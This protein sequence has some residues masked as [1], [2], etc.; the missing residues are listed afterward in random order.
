M[1][2]LTKPACTVQMHGV[3]CF[4]LMLAL[5]VA[6]PQPV[7]A[8]PG[9]HY[10]T[11][12]A[13]AAS[14]P[15]STW[16]TGARRLFS[17][18]VRGVKR[19]QARTARLLKK[20]EHGLKRQGR[21]LA[22]SRLGQFAAGLVIDGPRESWRAIEENPKTFGIGLLATGGLAVAGTAAGLP[23]HAILVGASGVAAGVE[24]V[25]I[26]QHEYREAK[27]KRVKARLAG[28]MLWLPV[29]VGLSAWA[30]H[31]ISHHPAP[32]AVG[33]TTSAARLTL[34]NAA[35]SFFGGVVTGGDVPTAAVTAYQE[36][37][38]HQ[39]RTRRPVTTE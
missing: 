18:P 38:D 20:A 17:A 21:R 24:V 23:T 25:Q 37:S 3:A 8:D 35:S 27:S 28:K 11:T 19:L 34:G 12:R 5:A 9:T 36:W 30:G 15:S 32:D 13:R 22:N 1:S 29:L 33:L 10:L 6:L 26:Y 2:C 4:L 31:A 14:P 39:K 16:R 7:R